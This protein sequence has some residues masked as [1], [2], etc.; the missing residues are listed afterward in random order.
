MTVSDPLPTP[1]LPTP[2][3][4]LD[5]FQQLVPHDQLDA[6]DTGHT[7]IFAS[8]V[9]V[10]L[11]IFQRLHQNASLARAV[12][13]LQA[14]AVSH[15]LPDCRRVRQH[16]ISSN[17]GGYS[18]AR[19]DLPL[20]AAIQVAD[21]IFRH[22][23]ATQEPAW[24][25]RRAYLIDG[26][27]SSLS[28]QGELVDRFPAQANQYGPSHW[29]MLRF[30]IAHELSSGFA[31]RPEWGAMA[32]PH[33][34]SETALARTLLQRL[35]PAG[36]IV[37]DR[38][39]GIFALAYHATQAGHD[40]LLRLTDARFQALRRGATATGP[41]VWSLAWQPS[42]WDRKAT[43]ELPADARVA[44]RLVEVTAMHQGQVVVLRV[45][46]TDREATPAELAAL[47]RRRWHIETDLRDIKQTLRLDR[48][49]GK[50]VEV[51]E[52]E[53]VLGIVAYNLVVQVR[54]LAAA[55]AG[56]E[57]RGLSF[58]RVLGLMQAFCGGLPWTPPARWEEQFERLLKSAGQCR[59]PHRRRVRSYPR[60]VIPRRRT[61]P[62]RPRSS[63]QK[64]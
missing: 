15:V 9:V 23:A 41:G 62:K 20:E 31:T 64:N 54:R 48:L 43:P 56:L 30:V 3:H 32:G 57:P 44:G 24:Q 63:V 21:H 47:Y 55:R 58:S 11:M 10:W 40:V 6:Y 39:F 52:K 28:H 5:L 35:G 59:L 22:L 8:W 4:L 49:W 17:T 7:G 34:R 27:T 51:V 13:E 16:A 37:G 25:G 29:P 19:R 38:N 18:Q 1:T 12:A 33:A 14:G 61:F 42:A 60:E 2:K 50:S 46:T 53:L 26:S 36:I 45:F